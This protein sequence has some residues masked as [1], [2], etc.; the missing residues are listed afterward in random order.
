[1]FITF[2]FLVNQD[3][4]KANV[5]NL[6]EFGKKYCEFCSGLNL[7]KNP[8]AMSKHVHKEHLSH[9]EK[10]I[11]KYFSVADMLSNDDVTAAIDAM[12]LD[13]IGQD[14]HVIFLD[15]GLKVSIEV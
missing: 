3:I 11:L 5:G 12:H 14:E 6:N 2:D 7:C 8:S 13:L 10:S 4:A 15:E 9:F 1:L